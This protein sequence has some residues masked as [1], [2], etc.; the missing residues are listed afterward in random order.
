MALPAFFAV[1]NAKR[2]LLLPSKI[3][4]FVYTHF[5][6][7]TGVSGSGKTTLG[8]LLATQLGIAFFDADTFHSDE[9]VLKMRS[10]VPLNDAD[11]APWLQQLN[12]F[13]KERATTSPLVLA[14]SAL[15]ERYREALSEGIDSN[16]IC[17]L[18]LHGSEALIASRLQQRSGHF[19]PPTLLQSQL[20]TWEPPSSGH[21]IDIDAPTDVLLRHILHIATIPP[22][23]IGIVGLGVMGLGLARNIASR[24]FNLA[25]YNRYV[26]GEEEQVAHKATNQY[27]E[28]YA[29]AAYEDLPLFLAALDTP[30]QILLMVQ[31]GTAID[32]LLQQL[33]PFLSPGDVL[34]DGGNSFYKDTLRRQQQTATQGIYWIGAGIS[35]GEEGALHGPSIMPGGSPTGY[36]TVR[37]LLES[38]A[39]R[40][41]E[42]ETC[43]RYMG[44][45]GAGHFV[46]MV[47]NGIEYA[48]MQLIAELYTH[49][50]YD[51]HYTLPDIAQ[52][53]ESWCQQGEH[54][55]L[56]QITAVI[57]RHP[58]TDGQPL[59][60]KIGDQ[61]GS[62]GT[63][64]WATIAACEWGVPAPAFAEALFSRASSTFARE[65][66]R[67][68]TDRS[69]TPTPLLRI[70]VDQLRILYRFTQI[71]HHLQGLHLIQTASEGYQ[72]AV[73]LEDVL[74]TWSGGC[75]LRSDLIH[76]LRQELSTGA[77]NL[78]ELPSLRGQL[79]T[80]L[81]TCSQLM[82]LLSTSKQAYP[83]MSSAL[84]YAK[85]ISTARS[86]ACLI[87]AQRDYFGAHTFQ[88]TDDP[89]GLFHHANWQ[90]P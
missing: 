80:P 65:R 12:T 58:D 68:Q 61:A 64:S 7:L 1:I 37:P 85:T 19:M 24:G 30:R 29:A 56:L 51:Q 83:Q 48:D 77:T 32:E 13:L 84:H 42:G 90:K 54:S 45:G 11:R 66:A 21:L 86:A 87:Q 4:R 23:K 44:E 72:W 39:A 52:V 6:I 22:R 79:G 70:P 18:H 16:L 47:H 50:R 63:G 76:T 34:I 82:A 62:K 38:I 60:D 33:L 25:L 10:G 2:A 35:G 3:Q 55:Y 75:I 31:A 40:N 46:K 36:A 14:C 20:T 53:F 73:S 67:L 88:R 41:A 49:L 59:L 74:H 78:F 8:Q 57:L 71:M 43:C 9:A 28:L 81:D 17:W 26:A 69:T 5:F 89:Q 15:T 27:P